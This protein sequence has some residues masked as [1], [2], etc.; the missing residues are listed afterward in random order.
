MPKYEY[1]AEFVTSKPIQQETGAEFWTF[2][3]DFGRK[4]G[5]GSTYTLTSYVEEYADLSEAV[6]HIE[7]T[8]ENV[9]LRRE[10]DNTVHTYA[11]SIREE[12]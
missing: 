4:I 6:T 5:T 3:K 8:I 10:D 2:A 7:G 12:L 9:V 11:I 1:T